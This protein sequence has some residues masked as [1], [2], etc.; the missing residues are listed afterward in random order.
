M[1]QIAVTPPYDFD[2]SLTRLRTFPKQVVSQVL[3]GPQYA[4][5]VDLGSRVEVVRVRPGGS[6]AAPLLLVEGPAQQ[7]AHAFSAQLDVGAFIA[8]M[9]ANDPVMGR[10]AR[11]LN[12]LKPIRA[13]SVWE[14]LIWAIIGQQ[15][16]LS[17]AFTLKEALVQAAG[18]SR[19]GLFAFP[20]PEAIAALTLDDLRALKFSGNKAQFIL[21]L[22]HRVAAGQV[23]LDAMVRLPSD[24]AM[25]ALTTLRGVG[26]WT[27][28]VV[29]LDAGAHLD[30]LPAADIGI[31]N[32]VTLFYGLDHQATEAEVRALGERWAP[33]R[34]LASYYLWVGRRLIPPT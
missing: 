9:E 23:D 5:A 18:R 3:P 16:N 6:P 25:R 14:S 27:A 33:W 22:A 17:F 31:R 10:L 11:R 34:S 30:M 20:G 13:F 4:R 29:L 15:I 19:E 32:A 26:R 21:D 12:G 2:L 24:E 1:E 8:A 7:V 28:E